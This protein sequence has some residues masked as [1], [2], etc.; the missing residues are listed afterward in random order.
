MNT[1]ML[2]AASMAV[3]SFAGFAAPASAQA[4]TRAEVRQAL[5]EA[6]QQ[7]S[8]FVTDTSYPAV[9]P[10]F[11]GAAAAL[12]RDQANSG[13]GGHAG[14][15]SEAGRPAAKPAAPAAGACVGPVSYCSVYF[16]S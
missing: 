14:G 2:I 5:I 1:S 9:S 12:Q 15:A 6:E 3:V 13:V 10:L 8:R 4:L 11:E 16:G 7:G